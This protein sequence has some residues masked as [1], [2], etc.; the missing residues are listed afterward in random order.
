MLISHH[1]QTLQA[2]AVAVVTPFHRTYTMCMGAWG[3]CSPYP[4]L[5]QGHCACKLVK[6]NI[7]ICAFSSDAKPA[8]SE[9]GLMWDVLWG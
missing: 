5:D 3:H 8:V 7:E 6:L 1:G 2:E 4:R 9:C